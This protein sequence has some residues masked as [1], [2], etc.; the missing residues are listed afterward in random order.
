MRNLVSIIAIL[1]PLAAPAA[2]IGLDGSTLGPGIVLDLHRT[3]GLFGAR[4]GAN[5]LN[6]GA[7]IKVSG[8][9]TKAKARLQTESVIAD[10]YPLHNGFRLSGGLVLNQSRILI[11]QPISY[12]PLTGNV[13]GKYTYAPVAPYLGIGYDAPIYGR[14]SVHFDAGAMYAGS[15]HPELTA[16]GPLAQIP[17]AR[18]A[19]NSDVNTVTKTLDRFR[20]YPVVSAGIEYRF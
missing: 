14:L 15:A 19:I 2:T 11:N 1:C 3:G 12:G 18:A 20:V 4:I 6:I 10:L 5:A 16:T 13:S 8:M 9:N 17:Q 7:N